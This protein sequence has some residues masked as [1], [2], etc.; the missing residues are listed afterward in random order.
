VRLFDRPAPKMQSVSPHKG[1]GRNALTAAGAK[2]RARDSDSMRRLVQ[3]WQARSYGYYDVIPEVKYAAQFYSRALSV[4]R[5][6]AG[7]IDEGGDVVE[8][9]DSN[10]PGVEMLERIQDPGGGRS[11]LLAQYGRLMFL[12]GEAYLLASIDKETDDEQWEM[13][14]PDEL[15]MSGGSYT[16]FRAPT[17]PAEQLREAPDDAYAPLDDEDSVVYRLWRRHPRYSMLADATMQGVLDVCE[18][19]VLLT[20]A[21]RS[22][23]RSRL[24]GPG[25]LLVNGKVSPIPIGG[26]VDDANPDEDPFVRDLDRGDDVADYRRGHRLRRRP[27]RRPRRYGRPRE[28]DAAHSDCRP[29]SALPGDGSAPRGGRAARDRPRYAA[30][31]AAR[32]RRLE[33]LER[34]AGRRADVEGAPPAGRA[35]TRRRPDASYYRPSLRE[36]G[37]DG[38]ARARHR[39]DAT[40][41]V[42]HPDR[43]KDA[44]DLY[45][46]GRS[47][48][49]R[50]ARRPAS[51]TRTPRPR[52]SSRR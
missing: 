18:E 42:N 6:Y 23:A 16:R 43:G 34:V 2:V 25:I 37:V 31:G 51:T 47:A 26:D 8:I 15:R 13:L 48:R 39:Y 36:A 12:G 11:G 46:R 21:V 17:L 45:D 24:A 14:S 44:K 29:D 3:P 27:A 10:D 4:L 19:L 28:G 35:A 49:R 7:R 5:L 41:I 38:L 20:Q 40:A 50:S 22:R 9:E 33:P 1:R 30:R 32:A 52:R